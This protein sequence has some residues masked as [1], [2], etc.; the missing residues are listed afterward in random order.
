MTERLA[1]RILSLPMYP[2]MP[3]QAL[4]RVGHAIRSYFGNDR[5]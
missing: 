1:E 3:M 2:H 4:V 5:P